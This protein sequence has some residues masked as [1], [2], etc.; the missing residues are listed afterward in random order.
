MERPSPEWARTGEDSRVS[1]RGK[2]RNGGRVKPNL[3]SRHRALAA[4]QKGV[5]G[6]AGEHWALGHCSVSQ[7]LESWRG[8]WKRAQ[9]L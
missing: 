2:G 3:Y 1:A 4:S 7:W 9:G 8:G 6:R 5:G